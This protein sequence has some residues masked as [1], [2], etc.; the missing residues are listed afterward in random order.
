MSKLKEYLDL[1]RKGV[2]NIDKITEGLIN[3]VKMEYDFLPEEEQEEITRRRLICQECPLFS[4]NA[5][6]DD[7]EYK[8]LFN[9]SFVFDEL[10]G[11]YCGSCGCPSNTRTAS[12]ASDCGLS[13]YNES[14]PNN[15]QPLKW[16]KYVK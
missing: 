7:T 10:R 11:K 1:V 9:E 16:T 6:N 12:L 5:K 13:Y 8:K 3:Q 4:L 14:N 2:P 15:K